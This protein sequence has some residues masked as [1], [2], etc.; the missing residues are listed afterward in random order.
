M[1][2]GDNNKTCMYSS[3]FLFLTPYTQTPICTFW[4][5]GFVNLGKNAH[6]TVHV[7]PGG[8]EMPIT[9]L[10]IL[11]SDQRLVHEAVPVC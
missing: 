9:L 6:V 4:L 11:I 10:T 3:M 2:I 8:L 1:E 5:L 7:Y